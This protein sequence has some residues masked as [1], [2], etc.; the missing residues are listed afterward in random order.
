MSQVYHIKLL[1][2]PKGDLDGIAPL[3]KALEY[4]NLRQ[5]RYRLKTVDETADYDSP[6]YL[7]FEEIGHDREPCKLKKKRR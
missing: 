1:F 4:I 7:I 6:K 3:C 2:M 5:K